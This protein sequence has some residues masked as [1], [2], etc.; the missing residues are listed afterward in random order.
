VA[1]FSEP[2]A[3]A[4]NFRA[5]IEWGDGSAPSGGRIEVRRGGAFSVLGAHRFAQPGTYTVTIN[6]AD[7]AGRTVTAR[8]AAIVAA[9]A[10]K[11]GP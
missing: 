6:I 8:G 2:G 7:A 1:E 4:R 10:R 5:S 9:A 11:R 3:K